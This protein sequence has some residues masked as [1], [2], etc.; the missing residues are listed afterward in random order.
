MVQL[1]NL[2]PIGGVVLGIPLLYLY[3][4]ATAVL[5]LIGYL[6]CEGS[7]LPV[8]GILG[9]NGFLAVK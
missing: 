9:V 3:D 8:N 2:Y 5:I 7:M 4:I 6:W 1:C